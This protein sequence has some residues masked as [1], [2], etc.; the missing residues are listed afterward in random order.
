MWGYLVV[1]NQAG[2]ILALTSNQWMWIVIT[3]VFLFGYVATWYS[4]LK[5]APATVVTSVL[6]MGAVVTVG[7][8]AV[9][10]G[11]GLDVVPALGL[12][13]TVIGA[14]LVAGLWLGSRRVALNPQRVSA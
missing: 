11:K 13:L 2:N 5:L 10:D 12:I 3:S 4:A 9:I 1:T 8:S 6:T 14:G 7:I